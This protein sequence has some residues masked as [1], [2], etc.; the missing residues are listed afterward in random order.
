LAA[1]LRLLSYKQDERHG[2]ATKLTVQ[3]LVGG[4]CRP[5]RQPEPRPEMAKRINV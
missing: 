5:H 2:A 3:P 4:D 1:H